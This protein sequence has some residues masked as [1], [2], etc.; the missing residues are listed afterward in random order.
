[1]K[2]AIIGSRNL[3]TSKLEEYIPE[4]VTEIVSGG[5]KGTDSCAKSYATE[6]KIGYREF[7]PKYG[8]Y[9]RAALIIRNKEIVDYADEVLAFRDGKSKGT[10][11]VISYC[12]DTGKNFTVIMLTDEK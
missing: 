3:Q 8:R 9:G 12:K 6:K 7:L 2:L 10:K 5:A 1:M 11:S 4:G